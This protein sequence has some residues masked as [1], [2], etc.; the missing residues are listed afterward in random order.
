LLSLNLRNRVVTAAAGMLAALAL[1]AP[2]GAA[3]TV[4]TASSSTSWSW[5]M[6]SLNFSST[7][8]H[9]TNQGG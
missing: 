1:A 7:E 8:F 6:T 9:F 2:A 4:T 5:G 3:D